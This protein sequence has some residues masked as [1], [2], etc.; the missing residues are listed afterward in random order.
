MDSFMIQLKEV[1]TSAIIIF[2]NS[3]TAYFFIGTEVETVFMPFLME[4]TE[5]S[6]HKK[7]VA[8]TLLDGKS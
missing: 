3:I 4:E 8:R 2:M 1:C 5:K 7:L 6:L